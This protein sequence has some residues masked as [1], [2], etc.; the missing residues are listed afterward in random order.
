VHLVGFIIRI[1]HDSRSPEL[2][3]RMSILLEILIAYFQSINQ[4]LYTEE[5]KISL[6]GDYL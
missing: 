1:F 4:N 3:I 6:P 5:F 2:Q